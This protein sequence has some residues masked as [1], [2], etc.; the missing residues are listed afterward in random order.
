M[1]LWSRKA[2]LISFSTRFIRLA[3]R[4]LLVGMSSFDSGKTQV[5]IQL[6]KALSAD[7]YSI[8][9]FKPLS[10]HNYWYNYD[11]TKVCLDKRILVSMDTMRV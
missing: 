7:N 5:A 10:G 8:E 4:V 9:Y 11:H 3:I 6:S 2:P 1:I